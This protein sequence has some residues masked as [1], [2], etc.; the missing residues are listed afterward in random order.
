MRLTSLVVIVERQHSLLQVIDSCQCSCATNSS[1][2]MQNNLVIS[3]D[4][5]NLFGI[6][7]EFSISFA[8]VM[9]SEVLNYR[10]DYFVV[11]FFRSSEIWPSQILQLCHNSGADNRSTSIFLSQLKSSLD[12]IRHEGLNRNE[13]NFF[14]VIERNSRDTFVFPNLF[15]P[16]LVTLDFSVLFQLGQHDDKR[17]S[18]L[19]NHAPKVFNR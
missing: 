11:L 17:H 19:V 8:P 9:H 7:Q 16:I 14:V 3:G 12:Q 18:F 1:T 5:C 15:R 2:A 13:Q 10:F 6:Q 4:I